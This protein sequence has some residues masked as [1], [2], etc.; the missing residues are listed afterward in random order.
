VKTVRQQLDEQAEEIRQLR[1]LVEH[2]QRDAIVL[3]TLEEARVRRAYGDI[4]PERPRARHLRV[5][6]DGTA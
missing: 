2:L 4:T 5:I 3:R 1:E 6:G